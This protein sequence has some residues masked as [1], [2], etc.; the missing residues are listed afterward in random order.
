[1]VA[2]W[3]AG[4]YVATAD[5]AEKKAKGA[6]DTDRLVWQLEWGAAERGAGR[7][8]QSEQAF[9]AADETLAYW[10]QQPDISLSSEA[11][12]LI[13]NMSS[14]PYRGTAYDR[15]MVSTYQALN[16]LT[17]GENDKARVALNRALDRQREAVEANAKRLEKTKAEATTA[18]PGDGDSGYDVQRALADGQFAAALNANY[19]ELQGMRAYADYVNPFSVWLHGVYFMANADGNS[20]V[21]RSH[22]SLQRVAGM[23]PQCAA[24]Q[25]DYAL[26]KKIREAGAKMPD[27]TY[28]IFETGQ[29]PARREERIDIPLLVVTDRLPYVGAAFPKLFFK[30][31]YAANLVVSSAGQEPVR[32]EVLASMDSVIATDFSNALPEIITRTLINM[33]IKATASYVLNRTARHL[34]DE[35]SDD[36]TYALIYIGTL[37]TTSVYSYSTTRADLRT[38][39]TL[40]KE[41]QI[42]R[43]ATPPDRK[44]RLLAGQS[45]AVDLELIPGRVNVVYVRSTGASTPLTVS[46]F[47]L[48][49]RLAGAEENNPQPN[50]NHE[51]KT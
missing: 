42:A 30:G 25:A 33:G 6:G 46:Q 28:V 3:S 23:L 22:L 12:S 13:N 38:W 32:T 26:I 19:G 48:R 8:A 2:S 20:E 4:Q 47:D 44:L 5:F 10:E 21:E 31:N 9:A 39:L 43:L 50:P 18:K 17:L 40:P 35:N 49:P 11:L 36:P 45:P 29:A 15:I 34:Y 14:L 24:V 37:I 27:V 51:N 1:M 41:F 7:F 16:Y